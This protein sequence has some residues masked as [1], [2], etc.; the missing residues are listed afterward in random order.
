M[1]IRTRCCIFRAWKLFRDG[2]RMETMIGGIKRERDK[3]QAVQ[4]RKDVC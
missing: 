4:E 3:E 1:I 2:E